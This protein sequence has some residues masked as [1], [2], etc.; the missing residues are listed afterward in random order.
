[1]PEET[2]NLSQIYR[3]TNSRLDILSRRVQEGRDCLAASE[4]CR[5]LLFSGIL[6]LLKSHTNHET[7]L[8]KI[9]GA[10]LQ[11]KCEELLSAC[12]DLL[13]TNKFDGNFSAAYLQSLH[14]KIDAMEKNQHS[15][16]GYL[17]KLSV[18]SGV[19]VTAPGVSEETRGRANF[20]SFSADV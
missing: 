9:D 16:A 1:M 15:I 13:R 10:F 4:F 2:V 8:L 19:V 7:G 14:E 3:E 20:C 6:P 12:N 17:S 18:A 11:W 5:W